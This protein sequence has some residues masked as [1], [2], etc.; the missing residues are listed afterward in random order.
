MLAGAVGRAV[1]DDEHVRIEPRASELLQDGATIG[2]RFSAS[3]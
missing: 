1:V 2:S 3:L